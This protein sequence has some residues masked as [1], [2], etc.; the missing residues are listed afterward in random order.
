MIEFLHSARVKYTA[1]GAGILALE[2]YFA[3]RAAIVVYFLLRPRTDG[4]SAMTAA[5]FSWLA[6]VTFGYAI[7]THIKDIIDSKR[8]VFMVCLFLVVLAPDWSGVIYLV[9]GQTGL[10]EDAVAWIF[11]IGQCIFALVPFVLGYQMEIIHPAI[12]TE[13]QQKH[14]QRATHTRQW[15]QKLA[16][17]EFRK[18]LKRKIKRETKNH[19]DEAAQAYLTLLP[20]ELG[21]LKHAVYPSSSTSPAITGQNNTVPRIAAPPQRSYAPP[22]NPRQMFPSTPRQPV[23]QEDRLVF[24]EDEEDNLPGATWTENMPPDPFTQRRMSNAHLNQSGDLH[25]S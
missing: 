10:T 6:V 22:P 25:R 20:G 15:A 12:I 13:A 7:S 23:P 1:L 11:T 14:A 17:K 5:M 2:G 3:V 4:L 24:E 8:W 16:M 18:A 19:Q 21:D 9:F